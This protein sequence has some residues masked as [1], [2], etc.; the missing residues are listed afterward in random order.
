MNQELIVRGI[1]LNVSLLGE[2]DKRLVI[3]TAERGKITVFANGARR[4]NSRFQAVSQSFTMG[5]FTVREGRNAYTLMSAE[6]EK[7]FLDLSYDMERMCYASYLC[8]LMAYYTHEG[9]GAGDELNLLYVSFLALLDDKIP[10]KLIKSVFELKL[11][12][13]EGQGLHAMSCV[14]CGANGKLN[15]IQVKAGGLL[16]NNCASGLQQVTHL[17]DGAV[18]TLQ[19]ILAAR[20]GSLYSFTVTEEIYQEISK[21]ITAFINEYVDRKFN[22]LDILK[23]LT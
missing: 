10:D 21:V 19:Y 4:P 17:S 22:S 3:L 5:R 9:I 6:I 12:D 20:I 13:I 16:C 14:K 11:M 2:Y 8:E 1:V 23:S 15:H 7:S 18:Y